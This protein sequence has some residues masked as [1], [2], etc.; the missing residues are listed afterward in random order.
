MGTRVLRTSKN[1]MHANRLS[2]AQDRRAQ[3]CATGGAAAPAVL[4][5]PVSLSA[6][7]RWPQNSAHCSSDHL[8]TMAPLMP[9]SAVLSAAASPAAR[10]AL[11]SLLRGLMVS[12]ALRTTALS[13]AVVQEDSARVRASPACSRTV[14]H[15]AVLKPHTP[16]THPLFLLSKHVLLRQRVRSE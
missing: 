15:E 10:V 13:C 11:S 1:T 7:P 16:H 6:K 3:A 2:A 4:S 9:M 5:T 8:A 12:A 14:S